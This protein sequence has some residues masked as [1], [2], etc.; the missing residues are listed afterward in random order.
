M[1]LKNPQEPS[2]FLKR[3]GDILI[4]YQDTA[5]GIENATISDTETVISREGHQL[6]VSGKDVRKIKLYHAEET[7]S[8]RRL[9][10]MEKQSVSLYRVS[11]KAFICCG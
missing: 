10:R 5:T 2:Y 4:L 9:V 6:L 1:E 8:D 7:C 11:D 3:K